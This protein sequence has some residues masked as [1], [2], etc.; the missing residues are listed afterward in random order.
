M[1]GD[2]GDG[3]VYVVGIYEEDF[4]GCDV[5]MCVRLFSI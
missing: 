1:S 3:V 5:I 2:F 4:Y